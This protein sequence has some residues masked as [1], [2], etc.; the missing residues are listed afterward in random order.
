MNYSRGHIPIT[1]P[2]GGV[3]SDGLAAI[4]SSNHGVEEL[5]LLGVSS[6]G[7][8]GLLALGSVAGVHTLAAIATTDGDGVDL[9][10]LHAEQ[11]FNSV[12]NVDLGGV[13]SELEGVLLVSDA[14]HGVL[15]DDGGENDVLCE[16][17]HAYTSSSFLAASTLR[18]SLSALTTS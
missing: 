13:A 3:L 15:G 2:L 11:L 10:D 17:H 7:D 5:D 18:I 12:G 6:Q 4:R 16:F 9:G 14:S 8:D 1:G